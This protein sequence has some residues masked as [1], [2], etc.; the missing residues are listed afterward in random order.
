MNSER[1]KEPK[2]RS[3]SGEGEFE[4][5]SQRSKGDLGQLYQFWKGELRL[6][7]TKER[8]V[9]SHK[10]KEKGTDTAFEEP[11][12]LKGMTKQLTNTCRRDCLEQTKGECLKK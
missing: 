11:R 5:N 3:Y 6:G 4:K 2:Q 1:K 12:G 7:K 10:I 8:T 9:R